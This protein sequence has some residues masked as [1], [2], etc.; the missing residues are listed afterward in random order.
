MWLPFFTSAALAARPVWPPRRGRLFCSR[1]ATAFHP[2]APS[3]HRT[4]IFSCQGPKMVQFSASYSKRS[5]NKLSGIGP[6][7]PRMC[8]SELI[9]SIKG[10]PVRRAFS[11]FLSS[12]P[13]RRNPPK[14]L[15]SKQI[16]AC[17][18]CP[19]CRSEPAILKNKGQ[20]SRNLAARSPVPAVA[21]SAVFLCVFR[22][23]R[24]SYRN[25]RR[26]ARS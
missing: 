3:F 7:Y 14:L 11:L 21:G 9:D 15:V 26:V 23:E 16:E 17:L 6:F 24:S 19:F 4:P 2:I 5:R 8:Y 10:L 22:R 20:K 25:S 12:A 13:M 18:N 1:A